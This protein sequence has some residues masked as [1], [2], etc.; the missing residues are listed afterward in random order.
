MRFPHR[1]TRRELLIGAAAL[2]VVPA[3]QQFGNGQTMPT[4]TFATDSSAPDAT[5]T[6][7]YERPASA[8]TEAL[9]VGNGRLGG[10]V[11]GGVSRERIQLNEDTL[12]AGGPYNPVSPEARDALPDIRRLIFA[13]EYKQAADLCAKH[14]M[15]RPLKQMQYQSLGDL[16]IDF[17]G[18]EDVSAYRRELDLRS[19]STTV[20][21]ERDGVRYTRQVFAS[22]LQQT[23]TVRM[24]ADRPGA[25]SFTLQMSSPHK[26]HQVRAEADDVLVLS[27]RNGDAEGIAGDLRFE[28]RASVSAVEGTIESGD[29][30]LL[31]TNATE[32]IIRLAMATSY[33][34]PT[35]TTADPSAANRKALAAA[36]DVP[37]QKALDAHIAEHRRLY[38]RVALDLGTTP[39]A[40][41][42][43]NQRVAQSQSLEDP[44][45]ATLF[46]N[47]GRYLL[48]CS[49]RPG[50]QPA[51]LQGIW[52]DSLTPPWGSKYTININ[53]EM[54]YWLAEPT[55]LGELVEPLVR[56]VEEIAVTGAQT[57]KEMYGARGW[58]CHHNTDLWRAT[59]PI[60]G[61]F[62]GMW[63][64]GGAWLAI[65]LWEHYDYHRD[66][67]F[68]RRVYPL[69]R[70]ASLFFVD[71]LVEYPGTK[72]LVTCPSVSPENAH[73]FNTSVCAGPVMD[74]QIIRDLLTC[75]IAAGE[76]LGED[77]AV[78]EAFASTL[79]RLAP[80]RI[81]AQGQLQEWF[82]DWD[83]AA[84][85][86][87]HR[88]ISHLY[89]LFPSDQIDPR[90][91]PELADAARVSLDTRGDIS[92][93]WAIAW[94]INCRAALGEGNRA[95]S[96]LR[97][98]LD[99]TRT[100][101]NLF[102]AHPPFQIDGNFGGSRAIIEMLLQSR[103]GEVRLLPALPDAWR[104]GF[105]RGLRVR[106]GFVIDMSWG[107][108]H[109]RD[110][111]IH[112]P[113]RAEIT[114]R[115]GQ[116]SITRSPE[117]DRPIRVTTADFR[118]G[119]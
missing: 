16:F 88:H 97:H 23:I 9:P 96:I 110:A 43:T 1:P 44:A 33:R 5:H 76:L 15:A 106:G 62:W 48:I 119:G 19:A 14:V 98:L 100:Y 93:G 27:G 81:G 90:A 21:Y 89:A 7:W 26:Q 111:V 60:D 113:H 61:P 13:R 82:E 31:V 75:T 95:H 42:P 51:N 70:D 12:W 56:L 40:S 107:D 11:F 80:N 59:A 79:K 4:T 94:R 36:A 18:D 37:Y 116:Q 3:V 78:R 68:L 35:D 103:C 105:V 87:Q 45:L 8:W 83:A 109:L 41:L 67:A 74:S 57:A 55:G 117:H 71:T 30:R 118:R 65:H 102:D 52:N 58:V 38:D 10:M 64:C 6:L 84:P 53:T 22:P 25:L 47:Y 63:P 49:S 2:V 101:P 115:Y 39:A 50:T 72:Q 108:G 29:D 77:A 114:L 92:T 32:V 73:P 66:Q 24:L 34:S 46:F 86:Q 91:T 104:D 28:A 20:T 85:E 69:L 54:N 99:P 17:G 112:H